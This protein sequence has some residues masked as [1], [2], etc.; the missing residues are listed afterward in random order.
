[1]RK[2]IKNRKTGEILVVRMR[3]HSRDCY[4]CGKPD[5]N[6]T[7]RIISS[8]EI[9]EE[10]EYVEDAADQ[11]SPATRTT[12]EENAGRQAGEESL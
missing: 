2:Q 3:D 10:W 4:F 8:K 12:Q 6:Y 7:S 5:Y 11:E 9:D 1:M